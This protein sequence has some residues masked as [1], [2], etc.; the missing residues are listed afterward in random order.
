MILLFSK[1][2]IYTSV[3][4]IGQIDKK[5]LLSCNH[6]IRNSF[7]REYYKRS[8]RAG[9]NSRAIVILIS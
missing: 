1:I 8:I 6:T 7:K 4:N 9:K 2:N 5:N 3:K